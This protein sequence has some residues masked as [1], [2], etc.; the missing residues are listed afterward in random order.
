MQVLLQQGLTPLPLR[1]KGRKKE[2]LDSWSIV[3][4]ASWPI[5]S[6]KQTPNFTKENL[7]P[8]TFTSKLLSTKLSLLAVFFLKL[9]LRAHCDSNSPRT[10]SSIFSHHPI[11]E[12]SI[13]NE[14]RPIFGAVIQLPPGMPT[15]PKKVHIPLDQLESQLTHC[16]CATQEA[17]DDSSS[18]SIPATHMGYLDWLA[19]LFLL[20]PLKEWTNKQEIFPCLFLLAS[21]YLSNNIIIFLKKW[22]LHP[23]SLN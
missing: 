3:W 4:N 19:Q 2:C 23:I 5:S 11:E 15:S 17:T 7:I 20:W 10:C 1:P 18:T 9:P 22:R 14:D 16:Q 13:K 8:D 12:S 6:E 21:P